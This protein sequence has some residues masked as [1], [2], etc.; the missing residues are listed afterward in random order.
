MVA[1]ARRWLNR[2]AASLSILGFALVAAAALLVLTRRSVPPDVEA[3]FPAGEI[4]VGVDASYPPF[5]LDSGGSLAGLDIDLASAIAREIDRPIRFVNIG[6]YALHD[7]LL[8]GRVDLLISALRVDPA[9]MDDLRYT[10]SYFDNGLVLVTRYDSAATDIE[11][12]GEARIA[13]EFASSAEILLR[14]WEAEGRSLARLPYEIPQYALDSLRLELADGAIVDA[15]TLRL[16]QRGRADWIAQ[17]I[18]LT[19]DPYVIALRIDRADAWKLVE[20]A[21][22]ALKESGEL[23]TIIGKWL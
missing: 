2:H 16:Y 6:F 13:Y 17:H 4:V 11:A 3:A 23:A 15:T 12:L 8:S 22:G 7:A 18:Y 21:L 20:G 1:T 5:A 9:R 19:N 14:D 10:Q